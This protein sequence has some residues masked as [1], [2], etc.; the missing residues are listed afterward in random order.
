MT[1]KNRK[2]GEKKMRKKLV[3]ALVSAAMVVSMTATVSVHAEE[4]ALD[5]SDFKVG[6]VLDVGGVNDGSFNQTSNEGLQK[7]IEDFGIEG[8][9]LESNGDADYAANIESFLDE[10]YD[11]IISVGYMLADATREAAEANPDTKFAII[12]DSSCS[13]LD[14][15]TC[16]MFEQAQGSYLV[17]YIAGLMTQTNTIGIV[18]GMAT[19]SMHEFGY[20]YVAGAID[21]N[22]DITVLQRNANSFADA[23]TGKAAA[24]AMITDGA[25]IIFHAAGGTGRGVIE[26]CNE[27][28]GIYA[29]GVDTDQSSL[30]PDTVI[31][32]AMK[33]VDTAVYDAIA[34]MIKGE[35][36]SG[37]IT[38]GL[39]DDG[40][41]IAPTQDLLPDDVTAAVEEV[42]EKIINGE[43]VVP[44]TQE[45]FEAAYGDVYELD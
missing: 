9:Y 43:V 23:E 13:D 35:L 15:V 1:A 11:L 22:P 10:D 24:N 7:A 27:A 8:N 18:L 38:Y 44:S 5:G 20:G 29:I 33:R 26:A 3:A 19:E 21:A 12:D 31:T 2:K 41:G 6:L 37:V 16:L 34:N 42:S 32:S 17:G 40:V 25:D 45:E 14:N 28:D 39:E 30:A 36:E 4:E